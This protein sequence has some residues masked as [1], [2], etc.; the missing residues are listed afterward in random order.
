MCGMFVWYD[1]MEYYGCIGYCDD[2]VI[3]WCGLWWV[4]CDVRY[5]CLCVGCC[6]VVW[7]VG[8]GC[9]VIL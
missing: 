2:V 7:L 1:C 4:S 5:V 3:F 6:V 9:C 8:V